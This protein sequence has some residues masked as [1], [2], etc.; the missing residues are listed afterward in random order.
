MASGAAL[1]RWQEL[2]FAVE[3]SLRFP[4]DGLVARQEN[5]PH[6][7][8][9]GR[10]SEKEMEQETLQLAARLGSETAKLGILH[11]DHETFGG[12]LL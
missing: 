9:C 1:P 10:D 12:A 4:V 8:R 6:A 2:L 5:I 7:G 3:A 11:V